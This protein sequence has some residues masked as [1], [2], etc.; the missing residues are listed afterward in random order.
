MT[1][2]DLRRKIDEV[3]AK[4]VRLIADRMRIAQEIGA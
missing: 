4:I 1:V 3:D 2:K